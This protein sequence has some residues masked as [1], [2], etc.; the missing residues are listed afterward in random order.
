MNT[1]TSLSPSQEGSAAIIGNLAVNSQIRTSVG[2]TDGI[3][4][5]LVNL[6]LNGT[7]KGKSDAAAALGNLAV[8]TEMRSSILEVPRVLYGLR[9]MLMEGSERHAGEAACCLQN[10]AVTTIDHKLRIAATEDLLLGLVNLML[11]CEPASQFQEDACSAL[12]N[13]IVGCSENKKAVVCVRGVMEALCRCVQQGS[14]RAKEHAAA[15]VQNLTFNSHSNRMLVLVE[16]PELL[17]AL[18][19]LLVDVSPGTKKACEYA[20]SCMAS[21]A[22]S[23]EGAVA[24]VRAQGAVDALILLATPLAGNSMSARK[25]SISALQTLTQTPEA[26]AHL[27]K[28]QVVE[29]CLLPVLRQVAALQQDDTGFVSVLRVD[30]VIIFVCINV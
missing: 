6:L 30:A 8:N 16:A 19:A 28:S 21:I 18:S 26:A 15:V 10:L 25:A 3:I 13:L 9:C 29:R 2:C 4:E 7:E 24:V 27:I 14:V 1:Y 23:R 12:L 17:A 20:A 11:N 5:G 22:R